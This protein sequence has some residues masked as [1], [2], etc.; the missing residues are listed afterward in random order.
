MG[1]EGHTLKDKN[2]KD[3]LDQD[4]DVIGPKKYKKLVFL[5]HIAKF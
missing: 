2:G 5:E 3:V 1:N 4:R